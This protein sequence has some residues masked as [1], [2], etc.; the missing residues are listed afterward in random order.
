MTDKILLI[1]PPD[2]VFNQAKSCLM[3]YPG[4]PIRQEYQNILAESSEPQN[5]YI[6]NPGDEDADISWLLDVIHLVD[7]VIF[8][9]DNSPQDVKML[10]SYIVSL[11]KTYWL[12]S[13]DRWCYNKLSL[14]RIYGLDTVQELLGGN[15]EK[16]QG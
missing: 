3:I 13:E 15:I 6:Y 14:N 12:T 5:I 8:D 11:P 10:A 1:T 16:P 9:I 2:K 4:E 7:I